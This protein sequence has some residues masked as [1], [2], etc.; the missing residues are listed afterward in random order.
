MFNTFIQSTRNTVRL[1]STTSVSKNTI[2]TFG[3]AAKN[4]SKLNK[5][6]KSASSVKKIK[7]IQ[8]IKNVLHC[9]FKKNNT[10]LTLTKV[11]M[12]KNHSI[13]N[14]QLSFNE[15]VL[16]YL[17]LPQKITISQSTGYLG[18]RKAQRGEYEASFQLSSNI[19]KSINEKRLLQDSG[20]LEII[21]RGFGKGRKAFFDALKGKEGNGIREYISRLSD[22]T[23]I[24]FGGNRGPARRRI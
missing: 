14:P 5:T 10:F 24:A 15:K 17:T 7:D 21:V 2:T 12:D 3:D 4:P 8:T 18:F 13:N 1:F 23:P 20:K 19:F 11:Q 9:N 6:S 22:L 16:Y